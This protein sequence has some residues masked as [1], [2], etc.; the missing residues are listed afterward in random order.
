MLYLMCLGP[1]LSHDTLYYYLAALMKGSIM[2]MYLLF[3]ILF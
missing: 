2:F 3:N 1:A